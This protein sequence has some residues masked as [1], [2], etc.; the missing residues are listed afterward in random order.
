ML[1]MRFNHEQLAC[2]TLRPEV[3]GTKREH[4]VRLWFWGWLIVA[5][6]IALLS[7]V[8]RDRTAAPFAAG[9]AAAVLIES[10]KGSPGWEWIAFAGV[11]SA[12]FIATN[13]RR[14]S[15]RHARGGA[16]R[17]SASRARRRS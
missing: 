8:T 17:H 5:V 1:F 2:G 3:V 15:P 10:F 4:I 11:S 16:G 6:S 12:V 14:Y 13:R 9:A 7:V